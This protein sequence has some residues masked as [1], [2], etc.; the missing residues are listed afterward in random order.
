MNPVAK[1]TSL[2][3]VQPH[4]SACIPSGLLS[5]SQSSGLPPYLIQISAQPSTLLCPCR[6]SSQHEHN[7]ALY[8]CSSLLTA[9]LEHSMRAGA[10]VYWSSTLLLLYQV[11][12]EP[13]PCASYRQIQAADG[14]KEF[15]QFCE[16]TLVVLQAWKFLRLG[17]KCDKHLVSPADEVVLCGVLQRKMI[18]EVCRLLGFELAQEIFLP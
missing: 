4:W 17:I 5:G 3:L 9:P 2:T 16:N 12:C 6:L 13:W 15:L 7:W 18:Q 14:S 1:P 10:L 8:C 11:T